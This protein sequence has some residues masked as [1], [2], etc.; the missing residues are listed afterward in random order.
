RQEIS[1]LTERSGEV[2]EES[3]PEANPRPLNVTLHTS[4]HQEPGDEPPRRMDL[5][6]PLWHHPGRHENRDEC[7]LLRNHIECDRGVGKQ[8]ETGPDRLPAALPASCA[9]FPRQSPRPHQ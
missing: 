4:A 3:P 1:K 7:G 9:A 2:L 5:A 6:S 8:N